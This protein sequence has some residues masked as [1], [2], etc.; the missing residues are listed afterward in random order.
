M[1]NSNHHVRVSPCSDGSDGQKGTGGSEMKREIS[2]RFPTWSLSFGIALWQDV[3]KHRVRCYVGMVFSKRTFHAHRRLRAMQN[4]WRYHLGRRCG[5]AGPYRSSL[6]LPASAGFL[7]ST[8]VPAEHWRWGHQESW[9]AHRPLLLLASLALLWRAEWRP[10][11]C[12]LRTPSF[13]T[14]YGLIQALSSSMSKKNPGVYGFAVALSGFQGSAFFF[15][16]SRVESLSQVATMSIHALWPRSPTGSPGQRI[17]RCLWTKF[18]V[19]KFLL[20]TPF[21]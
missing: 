10:L 4:A 8:R 21:N 2:H 5:P 14:M 13:F 6:P 12:C 1:S 3:S 15:I 17:M 7:T 20:N 9:R 19:S 18:Q 16:A 11:L